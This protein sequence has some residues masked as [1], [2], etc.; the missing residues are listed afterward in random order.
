M[1][2]IL[3]QIVF[4]LSATIA[5]AQTDIQFSILKA[6]ADGMS[7]SVTNALDLKLRQVFDRNGAGAADL[8]N[9]FAIEPTISVEKI[10]S[11]NSAT[12]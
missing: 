5:M 6:E 8:Y 10:I 9:V 3:L 7:A 2:K 12:L 4:F 11:L 1:K